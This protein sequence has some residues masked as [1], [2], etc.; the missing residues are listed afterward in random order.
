MLCTSRTFFFNGDNCKLV[1]LPLR[2]IRLALRILILIFPFSQLDGCV[3]L[4]YLAC[5]FVYVRSD[6]KN[7]HG[8]RIHIRNS[9][10]YD[11]DN[12]KRVKYAYDK[13]HQIASHTWAH[14][15][16]ST[17]RIEPITSANYPFLRLTLYFI[18]IFV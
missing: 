2:T 4:R 12:A 5:S 1:F 17:V 6:E 3:S 8:K 16:L 9:Q 7:T 13:G 18:F 15:D 14:K 11:A 10:I